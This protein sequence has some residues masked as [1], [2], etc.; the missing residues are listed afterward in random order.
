MKLSSIITIAVWL[1]L[2]V[3][4]AVP[5]LKIQPRHIPYGIDEFSP[6]IRRNASDVLPI[7]LKLTQ[8][9]R[10]VLADNCLPFHS[11]CTL[12]EQ[13]CN[14]KCMKRVLRCVI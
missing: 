6:F 9:E 8:I 4:I 5:T 10:M 2:G 13:C 1:F 12:A 14:L 7:S 11:K 3:V